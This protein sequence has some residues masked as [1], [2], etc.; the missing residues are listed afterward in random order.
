MHEV[1]RLGEGA[2]SLLLFQQHE[3]LLVAGEGG[4]GRVRLLLQRFAPKDVRHQ[5]GDEGVHLF[6]IEGLFFPALPVQFVQPLAGA[7]AVGKNR[8]PQPQRRVEQPRELGHRRPAARRA[9]RRSPRE[10][11]FYYSTVQKRCKADQMTIS[12]HLPLAKR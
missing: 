4:L 8:R 3:Q 12:V 7:V 11:V 6:G 5:R 10:A 2:V 1:R 9:G